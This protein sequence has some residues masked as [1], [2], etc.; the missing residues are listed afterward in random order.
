MR[1]VKSSETGDNWANK[2]EGWKTVETKT[3]SGGEEGW[4]GAEPPR[5]GKNVTSTHVKHG[6]EEGTVA[7]DN[8]HSATEKK[9]SE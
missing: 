8:D 9:V 6:G 5:G 3:R 1:N 4:T 7:R 2:A